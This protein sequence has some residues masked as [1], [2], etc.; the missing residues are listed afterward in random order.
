M[1]SARDK[2]TTNT[3]R[4]CHFSPFSPVQFEVDW[5]DIEVSKANNIDDLFSF[6]YRE[7]NKAVNENAPIKII[8]QRKL[9]QLANPW[10]TNERYKNVI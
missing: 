10:I 2:V 6:F 8:S 3:I 1:T 5:D 4:K 9:R 7:M